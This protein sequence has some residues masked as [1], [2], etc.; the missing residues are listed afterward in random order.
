MAVAVLV[1]MAHP[2]RAQAPPP[3]P[4]L[5]ALAGLA[6]MP[7][8]VRTTGEG[9]ELDRALA[10]RDWPR[11]EQLL[12]AAIER[13]PRS[14]ALLKRIADVFLADRRPLNAA[15]ALKK[16]EALA[17][18]DPASRYR[19]VLAYVAMGR[20]DWARPELD[21]LTAAAP[22][23]AIF[24]YWIGRL[25][26]DEGQYASAIGHLRA[27]ALLDPSFPRTFDNLGL[28]YEALNDPAEA[29]TAYREAVRLNRLAA[30][31]SPWPPLNLA[32]LLARQGALAEAEGLLREAITYD[33]RA[34]RALY[35]LG[36][37][38]EQ[39]ERM[40][41]AIDQL[42]AAADA[43]PSYPDPQY[44]LARVYRRLG[45]LAEADHALAAFS[46]RRTTAGV[47]AQGSRTP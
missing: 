41:D 14:A 21:R 6:H 1:A 17:P 5:E 10:A 22:D 40:E 24:R 2:S 47:G 44:A 45:R 20:R 19:L 36:V 16:A 38:L 46:A 15:I 27:A 7:A 11:A 33:A 23:T 18:L 42:R 29:A 31:R 13:T 9:S 8:A 43:D 30:D 34:S 28:C 39:S 25:D 32:T 37:V 26:Y 4:D 35:Q 12:A 3:R